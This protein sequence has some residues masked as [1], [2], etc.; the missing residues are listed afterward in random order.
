MDNS[1]Q[2]IGDVRQWPAPTEHKTRMNQEIRTTRR[3]GATDLKAIPTMKLVA[4]LTR[5][6]RIA[7]RLM[8]EEALAL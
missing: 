3:V 2:P 4:E 6:E 1:V 8:I 5:R 7:L